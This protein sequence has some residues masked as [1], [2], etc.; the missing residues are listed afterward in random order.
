MWK[1]GEF[2]LDIQYGMLETKITC[3]KKHPNGGYC[4]MTL[5]VKSPD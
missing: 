2:D 4:S 1:I 5:R 3:E